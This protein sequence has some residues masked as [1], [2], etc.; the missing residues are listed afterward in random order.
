VI[1]THDIYH[2]IRVRNFLFYCQK[3]EFI[4]GS[5]SQYLAEFITY[6]I[7]N[8]YQMLNFDFKTVS[9][10]FMRYESN[11]RGIYNLSMVWRCYNI[12]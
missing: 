8:F 1:H 12:I 3:Q 11:Y 5:E 7:Q 4:S 2:E 6:R 9:I 10:T